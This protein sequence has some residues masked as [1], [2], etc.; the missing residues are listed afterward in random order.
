MLSKVIVR[1]DV[2]CYLHGGDDSFVLRLTNLTQRREI[3]RPQGC[4]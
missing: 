3:E 2:A 1:R 4:R